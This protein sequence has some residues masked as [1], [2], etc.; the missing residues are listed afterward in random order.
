MGKGQTTA[1]ASEPGI[2]SQLGLGQERSK[3]TGPQAAPAPPIQ[4]AQD[5]MLV[6]GPSQPCHPV[7]VPP[8]QRH[9]LDNVTRDDKGAGSFRGDWIVES[10]CGRPRLT[11]LT[12]LA[13]R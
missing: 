13:G 11:F 2:R 3:S 12:P 10:G 7:S 1:E 8:E 6:M 4:Q 5:Q 9:W